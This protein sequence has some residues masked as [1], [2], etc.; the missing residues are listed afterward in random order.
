[1]SDIEPT[2]SCVG[3]EPPL[4]P[5]FGIQVI[6]SNGQACLVRITRI[7]ADLEVTDRTIG[8]V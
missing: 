5:R 6:K 4:V 7:M 3:I 8:V 1:M 2:R